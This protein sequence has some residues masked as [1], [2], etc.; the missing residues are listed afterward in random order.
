[1]KY[2]DWFEVDDQRD[3]DGSFDGCPCANLSIDGWNVSSRCWRVCDA[4]GVTAEVEVSGDKRAPGLVM[5]AFILDLWPSGTVLINYAD[6][7]S[8]TVGA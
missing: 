2:R 3:G 4:D 7:A 1:M 8:D 6:G 5:A